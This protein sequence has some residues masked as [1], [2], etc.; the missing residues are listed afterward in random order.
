MYQQCN[1]NEMPAVGESLLNLNRAIWL[2]R[3]GVQYLPG[4]GRID[5]DNARDPSNTSGQWETSGAAL[6]PNMTQ[7]ASV[8]PATLQAGLLMGLITADS[9]DLNDAVAASSTNKLYGASVFGLVGGTTPL[10]SSAT[11]IPVP[12]AVG[13]EILRRIGAAGTITIVR[14]AHSGRHRRGLHRHAHQHHAEQQR[15]LDAQRLR[16]DRHGLRAGSLICPSDG[17]QTPI[18]FVDELDGIRVT[19]VYGNGLAVQFPRVPIAGGTINAANLINFQSGAGIIASAAATITTDTSV[20]AWIKS[21]LNSAG[22]TG[23]GAGGR[24]LFS[25]DYAN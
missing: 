3:Q 22:A 5:G 14:S 10:A 18:T 16:H 24:F 15:L 1:P 13:A 4:G 23:S 12:A 9:N 21:M 6:P 25:S 7:A 17:S 2:G 19:D 8:F 20:Q 11:A